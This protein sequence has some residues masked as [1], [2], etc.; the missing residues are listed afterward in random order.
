MSK[1]IYVIVADN[2]KPQYISKENQDYYDDGGP[3]I[4]EQYTRTA[5]L[6]R[7]KKRAKQLERRYG[8]CRIARLVFIDKDD[9]T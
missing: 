9:E 5:D 1:D 2:D 6:E 3:L 8:H 4:F 7:I